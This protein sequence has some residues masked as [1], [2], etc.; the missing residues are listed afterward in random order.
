VLNCCFYGMVAG[1]DGTE[2]PAI[3]RTYQVS[4][5]YQND[6]RRMLDTALRLGQTR[7][8]RVT[9][10]LAVRCSSWPRPGSRPV[11]SRFWTEPSRRRRSR[12]Q[13]G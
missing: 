4:P 11:S 5:E 13:S 6:L 2:E 3:L 8:G 1:Q 12:G 7:L 10:G 9:N